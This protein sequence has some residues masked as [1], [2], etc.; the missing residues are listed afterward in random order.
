[1]T[2]AA[3]AWLILKH[4]KDGTIV[5]EGEG[6]DTPPVDA[7]V[8]FDTETCR[9]KINENGEEIPMS[10]PRTK[11]YDCFKKGEELTPSD[12]EKKTGLS[13]K[14]V[15]AR[16][17]G[18]M[19]DGY[20]QKVARGKYKSTRVAPNPGTPKSKNPFEVFTQNMNQFAMCHKLNKI[21]FIASSR[22]NRSIHPCSH[23]YYDWYDC[24][25]LPIFFFFLR[26]IPIPRSRNSFEINNHIF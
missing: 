5:I 24:Y 10:E 6:R 25:A 26:Y 22:R 21:G 19:V 4:G 12:I 7:T 8:E 15:T 9:W 3:D 11:I 14:V 2:G 17:R 23:H 16:L 20:I 13:T 1:M 18:L